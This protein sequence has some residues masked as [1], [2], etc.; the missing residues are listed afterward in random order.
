MTTPR[1]ALTGAAGF[2]APRH[3]K[4]I[5]DVGGELAAALDPHDAVGVLDQYGR[6]IEFFTEPERF[7]R[8]LHKLRRDGGGIDWLSVC[9]PNH[10][11]DVH[12][13]MGLLAGANV[14]CEKPLAL[15][16]WG[17]DAIAEDEGRSDRH[18]YT[19]L[20]LRLLPALANLRARVEMDGR[21]HKVAM[22]Y[23]TPRG[24]WYQHSWKGN[25]E[26]SG[27]IAMN[28]GV[29]MF[30]ALIWIFGPV[31]QASVRLRTST[32]I[33][34]TLELAR[35]DVDWFL[36][37]AGEEAQRL[38]RVDSEDIP[39]SDGFN[40]LHTKLYR[41]TLDGLGFGIETARPAIELAHRLRSMPIR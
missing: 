30:D 26:R 21:R 37:I 14:I 41:R 24:N 28:I 16:P 31:A 2:V 27:G 23:M 25:E 20:Q 18:V 12:T 9:S 4:A 22:Y 13:R 15:T 19:V 32:T 39:F 38:I 34:G 8:H 40:E 1:F 35:A 5:R 29:H 6:S 3:M 10:L 7:D 36:S 11:H 33:S 17:L